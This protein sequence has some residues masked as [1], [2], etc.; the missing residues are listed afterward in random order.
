[1]G[2]GLDLSPFRTLE[3]YNE[4]AKRHPNLAPRGGFYE[5]HMFTNKDG[6]DD[7][8]RYPDITKGLITRGYSDEDIEKILGLNILRVFKEVCGD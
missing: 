2:I 6:V 5:R 8:S 4:W 3:G 7:V 1:V